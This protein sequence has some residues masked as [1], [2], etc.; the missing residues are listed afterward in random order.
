ML[1]EV[2]QIFILHESGNTTILLQAKTLT[3]MRKTES[4]RRADWLQ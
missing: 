2:M 1:Y 4:I 3:N